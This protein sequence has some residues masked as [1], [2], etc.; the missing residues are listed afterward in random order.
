MRFLSLKYVCGWG[1][2]GLSPI[3]KK[4]VESIAGLEFYITAELRSVTCHMGSH[5]VTC[6]PTQ[7]SVPHLN[8][9]HAGWY[10]TYL[11]RRD[12]RLSWP[13]W[14]VTQLPVVELA[15]F[16]SRIQRPNHWATKQQLLCESRR[17]LNEWNELALYTSWNEMNWTVLAYCSSVLSLRTLFRCNWTEVTVWVSK[18]QRPA[19]HIAVY[20]TQ[21][22]NS[23]R[24]ISV[25]FS[26]ILLEQRKNPARNP[27]VIKTSV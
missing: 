24:L 5:S 27:S 16:R 23:F 9:N 14:L 7:V 26:A 25:L 4:W 1:F 12:R 17:V 11:P 8:P 21:T 18:V 10:S 2:E 22:R 20:R 13:W 19:R 15:T 6:H 3:L